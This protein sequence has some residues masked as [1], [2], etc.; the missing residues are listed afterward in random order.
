MPQELATGAESVRARSHEL[1]QESLKK[2][3][4]FVTKLY[5]DKEAEIFKKEDLEEELESVNIIYVL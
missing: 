1:I 3:D 5:A 4:D 2:L